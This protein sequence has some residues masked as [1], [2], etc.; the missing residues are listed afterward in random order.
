[1]KIWVL[2]GAAVVVLAVA[3]G[4]YA[5][6]HRPHIGP[7]ARTATPEGVWLAQGWNEK[8]RQWYHHAGQGT[9]TLPIPYHWFLA[10]EQPGNPNHLMSDPAYLDGFGFIS[11]P[12]DEQDNPAGLPVGFARTPAVHPRT[13]KAINQIGFT[14]AA[15]HTGRIDYRGTHML[16]DGGPALVDLGA[17]REALGKALFSAALAPNFPRF[18]ARVLGSNDNPANRLALR[19][20]LVRTIK[21]GL[22]E[23]TA[24]DAHGQGTIGE[25]VGRLDALNRIGNE[26]FGHQ[27]GRPDNLAPLTAPV[28]FPHIWDTHWFDWVQYNGSIEQPM[29]RNAGEAM[30]VRAIV[31]YSDPA[32]PRFT[33]TVR[34]DN[35]DRIEAQLAGPPGSNPVADRR[36]A[37]LRPPA[38]PQNILPK[39]DAALAARGAALYA[40]RCQG[41]HLP[42]VGSD[43]FWKAKQWQAP[44]VASRGRRY[45]AITMIPVEEIGTDPAQAVDMKARTVKVD[46]TLGL[47]KPKL[48]SGRDGTYGFGG[49]LGDV[50]GLVVTRWYD[51]RNPPTS[52][53]DRERINGYRLPGIRDSVRQKDGRMLPSYAARPLDGI[54]ATPPF[55]HN[56]SVPTIWDL[57]SPL[58]ERPKT[59][60]LGNREYDPVK[61]GYRT[62]RVPR[63]FLLDTSVR[64]NHNTGHRFETPAD[65]AHRQPGIIGAALTPADRAALVE[66]LKTL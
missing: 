46:L 15:C 56:G 47:S 30:G 5:L 50:V 52:A 54:W 40:Q 11:S 19:L 37:G 3:A 58:A 9:S 51:S 6:L 10:L 55:L 12:V 20:A 33:S 57:L 61:L 63:G 8:D 1:M 53:A 42:P 18:A 31:N 29:I 62:T 49:A 2:A 21:L 43:A 60:W 27:M 23:K 35:L 26:V 28:A 41:C 4:G 36:F 16:I 45:L 34:V 65:P 44:T 22:Y 39:I 7:D 48:T 64:G 25:G 59:F 17:F 38:W 66:Y 14:C 24:E 32:T 13:G